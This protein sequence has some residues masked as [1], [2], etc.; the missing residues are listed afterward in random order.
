MTA[1]PFPPP[2]K[3]KMASTGVT[4]TA[5]AFAKVLGI[6]PQNADDLATATR[7]LAV[8]S[9]VVARYAPSAPGVLMNEAALRFG[10]YLFNTRDTL[11]IAT[12]STGRI[13]VGLQYLHGPAFRN[14]GAAMLLSP[15]RIRRAGPI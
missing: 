8:A 11:G 1:Q 7:L 6:D 13:D 2:P 10:A 9:A 4:L 12:L 15:W 3:S 5:S 14:S